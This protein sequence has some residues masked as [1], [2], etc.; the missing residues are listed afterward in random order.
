MGFVL[1]HKALIGLIAV[2]LLGV[3]VALILAG[4]RPP[5]PA[6][7]ASLGPVR[8]EP[9]G[10]IDWNVI[11]RRSVPPT[12][13]ATPSPTPQ[14]TGQPGPP[15]GPPTTGPL[16]A[17]GHVFVIVME[18]REYGSVIGNPAAPYLNG[19]VKNYTLASNYFAVSHPSLPNYLALVAG[20]TFGITSDC[21]ACFVNAPNLADQIEASGRSWKAYMEDMPAPCYLGG[22]SGRYAQKHNPFVYFT[23]IRNNASRCAAHVVPFTMFSTDLTSNTLPNYVWITPNLCNDMHDCATGVGDGWLAG[24][25]P[26]ILASAAWRDGGVLFITWDE[27]SSAAGFGDSWGGRVA[28]IVISP[29]GRTGFQSW[30]LGSHY[31]LLRTIEDAWGLGALGAARVHQAMREDFR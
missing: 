18:N 19:L 5:A 6:R 27:G 11:R 20:S 23:D 7:A 26:Q 9:S 29:L 28:T 13:V 12:P 4:Q 8:D 21:T 24:V 17:F 22:W 1:R 31:N 3:P 15:S 10:P 30:I 25:V 2:L 16:P 14:V